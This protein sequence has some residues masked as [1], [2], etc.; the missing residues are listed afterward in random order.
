[1]N[2]L[3]EGLVDKR[4]QQGDW[5]IS[6]VDDCKAIITEAVFNSRWELIVGYHTL[7]G[8]IVAENNFDRK[9]SYGKEIVQRL[10]DSINMS[11]RSMWYAIQFYEKYPDLSIL[12]S[13]KNLSWSKI[14]NTLLPDKTPNSL[15]PVPVSVGVNLFE[16]LSN[17]AKQKKFDEAKTTRYTAWIEAGREFFI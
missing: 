16:Q 14:V 2:A 7:G 12:P 11:P 10:A 5:Y 13:G 8:R 6:L 9:E 3:P 1:M 15:S 4:I 17:F